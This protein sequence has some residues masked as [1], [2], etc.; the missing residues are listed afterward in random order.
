MNKIEELRARLAEIGTR[1]AEID[2]EHAGQQLDDNARAEWNGLNEERESTAALIEELEARSARIAELGGQPAHREQGTAF[3]TRRASSPTGGDVF[4]LSQYR[5]GAATPEAEVRAMRDGAKRAIE[6]AHFPH[7]RANREDVQGHIQRLLDT[8]DDE[9][10]TIARRILATGSPTYRRAFARALAGQPLSDSEMRA[11]SLTGANGGFA[12]PYQLDPTIIPTS[13]QKV[14]PYRAISRV[15]TITVDEWRG[16]SSAGVTA[17]YAAEATEATDDAPTLAQPTVS[18]ERAQVFIPFSFEVGQDWG[19]LEAEMSMLIQDAKDD[20]E[21]VKFTT[22][23]G[24]NEPFGLLTGATTTVAAGGI[25]SFAVADIYKTEEAL[26]PRFR[27]RA[28]WGANRFIYNKVRQFDTSGG[29]ALWKYLSEGLANGV[30][31]PGNTGADLIGYPA[32]EVSEMAAALTTGSKIAVL[33]DFRYFIIVDRIGMS[34]DLIPHLFGANR[35]PTGQRGLYAFWR[36]S[37]KVLD[38]NAFRVL[39]TG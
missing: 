13:N 9:Q 3:H 38:A 1:L 23:T 8:R 27:P 26:P 15:E 29:A 39:V 20:V 32:N 33:G 12:V 31:T 36:N 2:T 30:P 22:G 34:M 19:S 18:T 21:A 14:N 10:G 6:L 11:M 4:D 7:E 24:T 16:V 37:S 28:Q 35:R 25:A 5:N 17:A